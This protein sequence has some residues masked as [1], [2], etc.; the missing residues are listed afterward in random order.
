MHITDQFALNLNVIIKVL[1]KHP[2]S[3][4]S[5]HIYFFCWKIVKSKSFIKRGDYKIVLGTLT[6]WKLCTSKMLIHK[7]TFFVINATVTISAALKFF[8][9]RVYAEV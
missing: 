1:S 7:N 5:D 2:I 3:N 6:W 9:F 4:I 8:V